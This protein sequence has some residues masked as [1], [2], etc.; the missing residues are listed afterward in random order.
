MHKQESFLE[1]ET[2]KILWDKRIKKA[3][4]KTRPSIN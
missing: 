3:G 4:L 1:N 2:Y